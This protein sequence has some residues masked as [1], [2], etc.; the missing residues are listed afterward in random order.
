M[1]TR[2]IPVIK[3]KTIGYSNKCT[4]I[5]YAIHDPTDLHDCI[6]EEYLIGTHMHTLSARTDA[7][8]HTLTHTRTHAH[9]HTHT[10]T[11]THRLD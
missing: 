3:V 5:I 10:H 11:Q 2:A 9:T 1:C 7:H 6:L 8:T 4:T